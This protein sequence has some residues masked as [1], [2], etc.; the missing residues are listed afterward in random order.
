MRA[1]FGATAAAFALVPQA[2]VLANDAT[3]EID[4]AF[5]S[6]EAG[7][8]GAGLSAQ[9]NVGGAQAFRAGQDMSYHFAAD[10]DRP[11]V[12]S[13]AARYERRFKSKPSAF[14][15]LRQVCHADIDEGV[16]K[17]VAS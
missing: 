13:F 4:G 17:L 5:G 6:V 16:Q 10:E 15:A 12:Q 3:R 8:S 7:W 9:V 14:A 11:Q 2:G 1:R